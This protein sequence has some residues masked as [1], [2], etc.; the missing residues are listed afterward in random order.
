MA[1]PK[2]HVRKKL[3]NISVVV[4]VTIASAIVT[5]ISF[6]QQDQIDH[7]TSD[8]LTK[9]L[10]QQSLPLVGA[11][12][13]QTPEGRKLLLYGFVA[14]DYGKVDAEKKALKFLGD[15]SI[16][17]ANSIEIDPAVE[18]LRSSSPKS[19]SSAPIPNTDQEWN[20]TIDNIYRNGAQ[21]LPQPTG[22]L[23]P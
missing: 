19:G 18:K 22:P 3:L 20:K 9:F 1:W 5:A 11:Q 10:H 7:Y 17:I 23:I 21:P 14:T 12:V 4:F 2:H 8:R 6:A 15:E 13:L 16:T